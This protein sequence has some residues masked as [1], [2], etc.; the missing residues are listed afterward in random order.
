V[1]NL[2]LDEP[3]SGL[4]P[5]AAGDLMSLLREVSREGCAVLTSSHDLARSAL[6]TDVAVCLAAGAVV[7]TSRGPELRSSLDAWYAASRRGETAA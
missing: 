4:D 3:T 6:V 1:R 5:T 2:I 7:G